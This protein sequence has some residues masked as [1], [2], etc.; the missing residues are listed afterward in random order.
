MQGSHHVWIDHVEIWDAPDGNL[1]VN[2]ASNW[3]TVSWSIFRYSNSP[4]A[5]DHRF[6]NLIGSSDTDTQDRGRLKVTY[7]HNWWSERVHERMPRVRF[8][9]VHVF[10]NYY[11]SSGNNYCVRAGVEANILVENNYFEGVD[12]PHEVDASGAIIE[13]SG[14]AYSGTSG[15]QDD[16]GDAFDP[17]Y[18]YTAES[19]ESARAAV[20]AN[21]G[22][23]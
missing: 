21:A 7:H 19:A 11:S 5:N 12:S 15:A 18:A 4:P 8:G 20:M 14:N 16:N 3:V 6:S 13:A 10:N 2:D 1:D 9:Q 17:P 23:Q 22:P